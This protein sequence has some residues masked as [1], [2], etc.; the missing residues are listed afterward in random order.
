MG[1]SGACPSVRKDPL[2]RPDGSSSDD[3]SDA[4]DG[5]CPSGRKEV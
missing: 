2:Y 4:E 3:D 1:F 5:A